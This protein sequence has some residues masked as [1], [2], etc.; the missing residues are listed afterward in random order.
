MFALLGWLMKRS[1]CDAAENELN[2][3]KRLA[4]SR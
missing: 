4:E 3:L 2:N 1:S